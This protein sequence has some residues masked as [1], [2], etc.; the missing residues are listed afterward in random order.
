MLKY[1]NMYDEIHYPPAAQHVALVHLATFD[2]FLCCYTEI[3]RS[4]DEVE[5]Q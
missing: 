5:S 2:M 4:V 3:T 1:E